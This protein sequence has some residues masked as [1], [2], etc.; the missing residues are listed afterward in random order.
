MFSKVALVHD[1]VEQFASF[2][3]LGYQ[4]NVAFIFEIL[5]ELQNPWAIKFLEAFDFEFESF[6]V[7]QVP[8]ADNFRDSSLLILSVLAFI[9]LAIATLPKFGLELIYFLE[10]RFVFE[11][12]LL[13]RY[14][15][16][17]FLLKLIRC[18]S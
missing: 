6:L 7:F 5:I 12:E 4:I 8:F 14:D 15:E 17:I 3:V 11:D 9:N 2:A 13:L 1:S 16:F 10:V 18:W